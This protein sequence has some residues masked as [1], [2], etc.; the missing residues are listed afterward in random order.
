FISDELPT[1]KTDGIC[2]RGEDCANSPTDCGA[3]AAGTNRGAYLPVWGDL[4]RHGLGDGND[5]WTDSQVETHTTNVLNYLKNSEKLDF[6][7]LSEHVSNGGWSAAGFD[8]QM[9]SVKTTTEPERFIPTMGAE[10]TSYNGAIESHMKFDISSKAAG[11]YSAVKLRLKVQNASADGQFK[12]RRQIRCNSGNTLS[13]AW[14]SMTKP[15]WGD[16][17]KRVWEEKKDLFPGNLPLES[18]YDIDVSELLLTNGTLYTTMS[19]DCGTPDPDN[20]TNVVL[21]LSVGNVTMDAFG[22]Y[23]RDSGAANAPRLVFFVNGVEQASP[24]ST[25]ADQRFDS[26][27]SGAS[28]T[29]THSSTEPTTGIDLTNLT[30][31]AGNFSMGHFNILFPPT[32][33]NMDQDNWTN[34]VTRNWADRKTSNRVFYD[35]LDDT[36]NDWLGQINHPFSID[37]PLVDMTLAPTAVARMAT[38]ELSGGNLE[39]WTNKAHYANAWQAKVNRYLQYVHNGWRVAPAANSDA[40]CHC[41]TSSCVNTAHNC[42]STVNG[43]RTGMW[44]LGRNFTALK[45]ALAQKRAFAVQEITGLEDKQIYVALH[46]SQSSTFDTNWWMGSILPNRSAWTLTAFARNFNDTGTLKINRITLHDD[47]GYGA[48]GT[49]QCGS[50]SSCS[51]SFNYTPSSTNKAVIAIAELSDGHYVVSAPMFF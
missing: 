37:Y 47:D 42:P 46:A 36:T 39:R 26:T 10:S 3:C 17:W 27:D 40:H 31:D 50:T 29:G 6:V 20:L 34:G 11:S 49:L 16:R 38:Y 23:T 48:I 35:Y 15:A 51:G 22:I 5:G 45:Q 13:P 19:G 32:S 43:T 12:V 8:R 1:V 4:H 25:N 7:A 2:G 18:W 44:T 9:N 30:T 33:F 41:S 24:I 28:N 21:A 14:Y